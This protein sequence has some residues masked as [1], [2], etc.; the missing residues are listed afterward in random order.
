MS[1]TPEDVKAVLPKYKALTDEQIEGAIQLA[2]AY[3]DGVNA[4]WGKSDKADTILLLASASFT[5]KLHF[6]QQ[7]DTY[8]ALDNNVAEMVNSL[9]SSANMVKKKN[10]F[11]RVVG[12]RDDLT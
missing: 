6:P 1:V 5:L 12:V 2:G 8:N 7:V 11:M 9:W 4:D 3:L 10:R